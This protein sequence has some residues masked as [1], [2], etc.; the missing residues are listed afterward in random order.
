M[1]GSFPVNKTLLRYIKLVYYHFKQL[2]DPKTRRLGLVL[3]CLFW[4]LHRCSPV[5]DASP[6]AGGGR[7]FTIWPVISERLDCCPASATVTTTLYRPA[8]LTLD[9]QWAQ[10]AGTPTASAGPG[11]P[12][13]GA[14]WTV[15]VDDWDTVNQRESPGLCECL[16]IWS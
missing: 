3:H 6:T 7:R 4:G 12:G 8:S 11:R 13:R 15:S 5:N 2:L 14:R 1:N 9:G 10:L 16:S